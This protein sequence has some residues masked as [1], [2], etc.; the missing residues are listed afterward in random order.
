MSTNGKSRLKPDQPKFRS[1][2]EGKKASFFGDR[3]SRKEV[4]KELL[5]DA[6]LAAAVQKEVEEEQ[7]EQ[8]AFQPRRR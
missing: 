2:A 7:I 5:K 3:G 6:L 8:E 4:N 1:H